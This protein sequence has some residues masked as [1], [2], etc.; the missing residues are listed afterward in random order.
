MIGIKENKWGDICNVGRRV[1]CMTYMFI[2]FQSYICEIQGKQV[3]EKFCKILWFRNLFTSHSFFPSLCLFPEYCEM[4]VIKCL[5][6]FINLF[7][8]KFLW[9]KTRCENSSVSIIFFQFIT[10][11]IVLLLTGVLLPH[12]RDHQCPWR[13]RKLGLTLASSA[14]QLYDL[15]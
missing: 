1:S 10:C 6:T 11:C 15:E 2:N 13:S 9:I 3:K 12:D 14:K 5:Q 4:L 7:V 8:H